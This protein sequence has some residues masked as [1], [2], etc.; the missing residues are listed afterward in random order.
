MTTTLSLREI[1][2]RPVRPRLIGVKPNSLSFMK[3]AEKARLRQ[4]GNMAWSDMRDP[5]P[6][7]FE[8]AML[9]SRMTLIAT[10]E[11]LKL[12]T[13][14]RDGCHPRLMTGMRPEPVGKH[15]SMTSTTE[16]YC[17]RGISS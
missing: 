11:A 8:L 1:I 10:T 17:A 15:G 14:N 3:T 16:R 7:L 4:A 2:V 5:F 13:P 9:P 6:L 12:L